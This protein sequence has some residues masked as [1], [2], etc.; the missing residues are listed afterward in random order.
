MIF[1][2]LDLSLVFE[3]ALLLLNYQQDPIFQTLLKFTT[4]AVLSTFH[5]NQYFSLLARLF[6]FNLINIDEFISAISTSKTDTE[7]V[8]AEALIEKLSF[9]QNI[10][11]VDSIMKIII[12]RNQQNE[13]TKLLTKSISSELRSVIF[14]FPENILFTLFIDSENSTRESVFDVIKKLYIPISQSLTLLYSSSL[15]FLNSIKDLSTYTQSPGDT[16]D[17]YRLAYFLKFLRWTILKS[18]LLDNETFSIFTTLYNRFISVRYFS[19]DWHIYIITGLLLRFPTTF[20]IP[21][22][23]TLFETIFSNCYW[24]HHCGRLFLR[25]RRI[26]TQLP[27]SSIRLI[28]NHSRFQELLT[29]L[30]IYDTI[31]GCRRALFSVLQANFND[32]DCFKALVTSL[33]NVP[34]HL[35]VSDLEDALPLL[36]AGCGL[37]SATIEKF[38]KVI[39]SNMTQKRTSYDQSF[40][41]NFRT[42]CGFAIVLL[43]HPFVRKRFDPH[44]PRYFEAVANYLN[45]RWKI[46]KVEEVAVIAKEFFVEYCREFGLKKVVEFLE[47]GGVKPAYLFLRFAI[48]VEIGGDVGK[49]FVESLGRGYEKEEVCEVLGKLIPDGELPEWV[50]E[51]QE[52]VGEDVWQK[53]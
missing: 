44:E 28:I 50:K 20:T 37:K 36:K 49:V 48:A 21:L 24:P 4:H 46:G 42:V 11:S 15:T 22:F 41:P 47:K 1:Q 18:T 40:T 38:M 39:Y 34:N 45:E 30:Q 31:K 7:T 32:S 23:P 26:I 9:C 10:E 17:C 6:H 19:N 5:V 53:Y 16:I 13:F 14:K 33:D 51:I 52:I 8:I 35:T 3:L 2:N 29:S 43:K 27:L 12:E 25:F